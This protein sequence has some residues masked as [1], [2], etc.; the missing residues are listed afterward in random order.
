VAWLLGARE[1][2]TQKKIGVDNAAGIDVW[3]GS[4][5]G[6][7]LDLQRPSSQFIGRYSF[8]VGK[9]LGFTQPY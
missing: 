6:V 1:V 2:L 5:E 8:D 9:L 4:K 7:I 3:I